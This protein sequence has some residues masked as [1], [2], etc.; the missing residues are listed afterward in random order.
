MSRRGARRGVRPARR[1]AGLVKSHRVRFQGKAL[2]DR[3]VCG[4]G[5]L[6]DVGV[7]VDVAASARR[8]EAP[9]S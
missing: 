3:V 1:G 9:V 2:A 7:W 8:D 4:V 6:L 5:G